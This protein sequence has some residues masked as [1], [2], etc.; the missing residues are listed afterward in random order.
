MGMIL[1]GTDD[2]LHTVGDGAAGREPS[3]SGR[4]SP[5]QVCG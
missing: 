1:V 2:G 5:H 4:P 3:R